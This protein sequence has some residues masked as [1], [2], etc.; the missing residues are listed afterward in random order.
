VVLSRGSQIT[1]EDLPDAI[2]EPAPGRQSDLPAGATLEQIE[3]EHIRRVLA[4]APTLE[5]AADALGIGIATL[6]RK[7]K[8]YHIE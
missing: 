4:R 3:E 2:F 6:W 7:R 5:D 8:R 1:K